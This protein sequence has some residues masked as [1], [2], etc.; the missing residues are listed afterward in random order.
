MLCYL[1]YFDSCQYDSSLKIAFLI[2]INAAFFN[3]LWIAFME[4]G[5][6]FLRFLWNKFGNLEVNSWLSIQIMIKCRKVDKAW[7]ILYG[8]SQ[9]PLNKCSHDPIHM[10]IQT[11][12]SL[13]LC[14]LKIQ[15]SP[16]YVSFSYIFYFYK[17]HS[18]FSCIAHVQ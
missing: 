9:N 16:W 12:I 7:K 4:K 1:C 2:F 17:L 8:S 14:Q 15:T 3:K 18:I 10:L 6:M 5:V 13:S 11:E